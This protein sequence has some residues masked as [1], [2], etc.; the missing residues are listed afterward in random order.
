MRTPGL[1]IIVL[2]LSAC[3]QTVHVNPSLQ[4]DANDFAEGIQA[5]VLIQVPPD[6]AQ[7]LHVESGL[8]VLGVA[9]DWKIDTHS[10]LPQAIG[11][12]FEQHYETVDLVKSHH[13]SC[14]DCSLIVRPRITD[15][16]VSKLSMQSSVTL[17]LPIYDA[18]GKL[19]TTLSS[20]GTSP[21]LSATRLG[22]G[23]AGYFVPFF[24]NMLGSQVV[25]ATVKNAIDEA[26]AEVDEQ[27][28]HEANSG[29][30]AR[31]WLP[32]DLA[33]KTEY[34]QY[35]YTAEQV[36][37]SHGCDMRTDGLRLTDKR[38]FKETYEA[39]CWGKPRFTINCEYGRCNADEDAALA[40]TGG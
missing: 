23:V 24:G 9:N 21:F 7:K 4:K 32:L 8:V 27:L 1:L 22:A 36:A 5:K 15:V 19:I 40:S 37:R 28:A 13:N 16:S 35:E 17:E 20:T 34:G 3:A 18:R 14:T 30:L 10:S 33:R 25:A 38:Y 12:L 11:R 31:T 29:R 2:L 26:L 39:Y 6:A